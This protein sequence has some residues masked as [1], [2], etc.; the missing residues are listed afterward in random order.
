MHRSTLNGALN[1]VCFMCCLVQ[2]NGWYSLEVRRPGRIAPWRD[3]RCADSAAGKRAHAPDITPKNWILYNM[4]ADGFAAE[5]SDVIRFLMLTFRVSW[6]T[7]RVNNVERRAGE[8]F[9]TSMGECVPRSAGSNEC[10][11]QSQNY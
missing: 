4:H 11:K 1:L 7:T 2:A 10:F 8:S 6:F 3:G 5:I 9:L